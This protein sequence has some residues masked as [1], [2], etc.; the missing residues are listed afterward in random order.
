MNTTQN[1]SV[2]SA[3]NPLKAPKTI[4]NSQHIGT[5]NITTKDAW[6]SIQDYYIKQADAVSWFKNRRFLEER[7]MCGINWGNVDNM[8]NLRCFWNGTLM[9][10][11]IYAR[12]ALTGAPAFSS[13]QNRPFDV[14][15]KTRLQGIDSETANSG[16]V[17]PRT[18]T[19]YNMNFG[20]TVD[21][22]SQEEYLWGQST[23]S[24]ASDILVQWIGYFQGTGAMTLYY[25]HLNVEMH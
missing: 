11:N 7:F 18:H 8:L 17:R 25:D 2:V 12:P 14:V 20:G 23:V 22:G 21:F 13:N 10:D 4:Y 19:Q 1:P 16:I 6:F 3:F 15:N 5:I 24:I 9:V